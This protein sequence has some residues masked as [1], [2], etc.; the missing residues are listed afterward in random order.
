MSYRCCVDQSQTMYDGV[1]MEVGGDDH[2]MDEEPMAD[3]GPPESSLTSPTAVTDEP[4]TQP[5]G[6]AVIESKPTITSFTKTSRKMKKFERPVATGDELPSMVDYHN[7]KAFM[8]MNESVSGGS[9][10]S[11][12]G[13]MSS[14]STIDSKCWMLE[15]EETPMDASTAA[16]SPY[17]NMFW[18]DATEVNGVIYLFGKIPVTE[19]D[20]KASVAGFTDPAAPPKFVSCCCAVHGVERNLLVLPSVT[21][22]QTDDQKEE[23]YGGIVVFLPPIVGTCM[24]EHSFLT[25]SVC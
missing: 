5:D 3:G 2:P 7:S 22:N 11:A 18:L 17:V 20:Q 19:L 23:R 16:S 12:S 4:N 15:E 13:G 10:A 25:L 14:G 9:E 8:S 6:E 21:G 24:K 1:G